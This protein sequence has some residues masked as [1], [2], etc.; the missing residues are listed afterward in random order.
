MT[1]LAPQRTAE[2]AADSFLPDRSI[3]QLD[4]EI[5]PSR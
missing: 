4:V 5:L 2:A 3:E 1:T